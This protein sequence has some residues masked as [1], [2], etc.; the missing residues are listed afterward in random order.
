MYKLFLILFL[1]SIITVNLYSQNIAISEYFNVT[2]SAYGE[3]VEL[4]VLED[5]VNIS[6]MVLRDNSGGLNNWRAGVRFTNNT[7]WT[8]LRQGTIIVINFRGRRATDVNKNDGYIEVDAEN[9]TYFS[10]LNGSS[11]LDDD[12]SLTLNQVDEMIELQNGS[13]THHL[14]GHFPDINIAGDD[15]LRV[16]NGVKI[17]AS[18]QLSGPSS[19]RIVGGNKSSYTGGFDANNVKVNLGAATSAQVKGFPNGE[20]GGPNSIFWRTLRQ[21]NWINPNLNIDIQGSNLRLEW[22]NPEVDTD[23]TQGFLIVQYNKTNNFNNEDLPIDSKIYQ[24][25]DVISNGSKVVGITNSSTKNLNININTLDCSIDYSF[26]VY[27]YRYNK[28]DF[29]TDNTPTRAR[30]R[31]YNEISFASKQFIFEKSPAPVILSKSNNLILCEGS[32]L[33]LLTEDEATSY[34]WYFNDNQIVGET[35][36][37]LT[38]N[39]AGEYKLKTKN[40]TGCEQES[41]IINIISE[42]NPNAL[43]RYDLRFI[44]D[45]TFYLCNNEAIKLTAVGGVKYTWFKNEIEITNDKEIEITESGIYYFISEN[46]AKCTANSNIIRVELIDY[47]FDINETIIDFGDV[48][49]VK[50]D[51]IIITNNSNNILILNNDNFIIPE[52]FEIAEDLPIQIA[53]GESKTIKI[54]FV[55]TN[56]GQYS[57]VLSI[58]SPCGDEFNVDLSG[59]KI[60]LDLD[61]SRTSIDFGNIY[62]CDNITEKIEEIIIKREGNSTKTLLSYTL[63]NHQDLFSI[64]S[65]NLPIVIDNNDEVIFKIKFNTLRTG[66]FEDILT[67]IISDNGITPVSEIKIFL[68]ANYHIIDWVIKD[69]LGIELTELNFEDISSCKPS[70]E[71]Y[72]T[73]ENNSSLP[74]EI[75]LEE[76]NLFAF[77]QVFPLTVIENESLR[78]NYIYTPENQS[79]NGSLNFG[80]DLCGVEKN[81]TFTSDITGTVFAF[82]VDSYDFGDLFI[83]DIN[84]EK[85]KYKINLTATGDGPVSTISE[86][87]STYFEVIGIEINDEINNGDVKE[88]TFKLLDN[89]GLINEKIEIKFEPCGSVILDLTA[90]IKELNYTFS[91]PFLDFGEM[92]PNELIEKSIIVTNDSEINITINE[93]LGLEN[94]FELDL[95]KNNLP[96]VISSNSNKEIFFKFSS[97]Q[98]QTTIENKITFVFNE[99]CELRNEMNFFARIKEADMKYIVNLSIPDN[100]KANIIE[101][102]IIT[103]PISITSNEIMEYEFGLEKIKIILEFN[104]TIISIYPSATKKA[105]ENPNMTNREP[106]QDPSNPNI[107]SV[108]LSFDRGQLNYGKVLNLF[109]YPTIGSAV[110]TEIKISY[111]DAVFNN[112]VVLNTQNGNFK[113]EGDC[114]TEYYI[115]DIFKTDININDGMILNSN[116]ELRYF[117]DENIKTEIYLTDLLGNKI[118][119]AKTNGTGNYENAKLHKIPS[120]FYVLFYQNNHK[121]ETYRVIIK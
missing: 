54:R 25:G 115:I 88:I 106:L 110:E 113:L 2:G 69:D 53:A 119:I 55:P 67:L 96:I 42:E 108:E 78:I 109:A 103:I 32:Q 120:G 35:S 4:I 92:K 77:H 48:E 36:R 81:I 56:S 86:I 83:C 62:S 57:G 73:I 93:I 41:N 9:T 71:N 23:N 6:G 19:V 16:A 37:T 65:P 85:S 13:S 51:E 22:N 117:S 98:E 99:P 80:S 68:K 1:S 12:G 74:V 79:E 121:S 90:N 3:W 15:F 59:N 66:N 31:A 39:Q 44:P 89:V 34:Q 26:R 102:E 24:L 112:S 104:S 38:I 10:I 43:I 5:N 118:G 63:D 70:V 100:L 7:L 91:H 33:T 40:E 49:S 21:P 97:S 114:A 46:N 84:T 105:L 72:I 94:G 76:N 58:I 27:A 64:D 82:E 14:L 95:A 61:V 8:N 116:Y 17:A 107:W 11:S 47:N 50:T 45:T 101:D 75:N 60:I 111:E 52:F 18:G 87:N 28:D 30:G 29:G 20:V